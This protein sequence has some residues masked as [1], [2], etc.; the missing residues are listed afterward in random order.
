MFLMN[1][2]NLEKEYLILRK[3]FENLKVE[4]KEKE[5]IISELKKDIQDT[6]REFSLYEEDK[7]RELKNYKRDEH[8][9]MKELTLEKDEKI[10]NLTS[11]NQRLQKEIEYLEKAFS[12]LGFDVK[13]MKDILNKL[14]D[15]VVSKNEIKLINNK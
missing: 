5:I 11:D 12:G 1:N 10:V 9:R 4:D 6:R 15:G 13:D 8:L 2:K 14:V 3:E 7:E